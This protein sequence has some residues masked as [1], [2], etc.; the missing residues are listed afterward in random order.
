MEDRGRIIRAVLQLV[1]SVAVIVGALTGS[2][3]L[4]LVAVLLVVAVLTW[5]FDVRRRRRAS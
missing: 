4:L 1:L 2:Q 3:A 5:E